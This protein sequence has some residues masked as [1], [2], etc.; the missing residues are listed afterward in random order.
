[1]FALTV[2]KTKGTKGQFHN[3]L[4]DKNFLG[5]FETLQD[6][7]KTVT[8]I[9]SDI[10]KNAANYRVSNYGNFEYWVTETKGNIEYRTTLKIQE[11]CF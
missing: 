8:S 6:A 11:Y 9:I 3:E 4:L 2:T 1:M 10:K 7:H 5:Y